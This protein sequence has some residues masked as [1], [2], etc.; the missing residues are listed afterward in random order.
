MAGMV[1]ELEVQV[2]LGGV[3]RVAAFGDLVSGAD[4][5]AGRDPDGPAAQVGQ[6]GVDAVTEIDDHV[7]AHDPARAGQF[8]QQFGGEQVEKAE[9]R[10]PA[11]VIA[12]AVVD[13]YY[14]PVGRGVHRLAERGE[15]LRAPG[16]RPPGERRPGVCRIGGIVDQVDRVRLPVALNPVAG[17]PACGAVQRVPGAGDRRADRDGFPP[18]CARAQ[19]D[20]DE[21]EAGQPAGPAA[22]QDREEPVRDRQAQEHGHGREPDT[23]HEDCHR[24][25]HRSRPFLITAFVPCWAASARPRSAGPGGG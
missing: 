18:Q 13:A 19:Q 10:G 25:G 23:R 14:Y 8:A 11:P 22:G 16:R 24:C 21:R 15:V 3:A 6:D 4:A 12:L 17:D 7:V 1:H 9:G 5:L 20:G 2:R